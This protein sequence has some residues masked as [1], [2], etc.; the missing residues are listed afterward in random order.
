MTTA[1]LE[2]GRTSR[3]LKRW[4]L[5][6]LGGAAALALLAAG[7]IWLKAEAALH[8]HWPAGP[9]ELAVAPAPELVPE[10]ERLFRAFGCHDCHQ[11]AGRVL[12]EARGVGRLVAPNL[13][14]S[15]P[16]FT[17]ADLVRAVRQGIRPDGTSL[18]VMPTGALDEISDR[19]LA[20]I[21]AY[22]RTVPPRPDAVSGGTD[23]GPLGR[24]AI[25]TGAIPF[26][27][28]A[29]EAGVSRPERPAP[30]GAYLARTI[31]AGCHDLDLPRDDGLGFVAP[32]L[33]D[34]APAYSADGF[35]HLLRTGAP[36]DGR[37]LGP[38]KE[39][40]LG[41]LS[42]LTDPEIDALYGYLTEAPH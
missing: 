25:A 20:A 5:R 21:L 15:L 19:D 16:G 1:T 4:A 28:A 13:T 30:E 8:R 29:A 31:C 18:V 22:L 36:L 27:A 26:S 33:R 14:R 38:M 41:A 34:V 12:F 6:L 9:A 32:A 11:D 17:D 3:G 42:H 39:A 24:V 40:A 23:W 37:D 7:G 35:R 2:P 10:G